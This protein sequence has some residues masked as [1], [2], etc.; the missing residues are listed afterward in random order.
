MKKVFSLITLL[1]IFIFQSPSPPRAYIFS[2]QIEENY[3]SDTT[4]FAYFKSSWEYSFIEQYQKALWAFDQV[5]NNYPNLSDTE[6]AYFLSFR[7]INAHKY[8]IDRA[9]KEKL[10][11]I[12]EAHHQPMHRTFTTSLLEDLYKKGYRFLGLEALAHTDSALNERGYPI[13]SSGFYTQEPQFGN[14]IRK[15]LELGFYVFPYDVYSGDGKER[16]IQQAK[17]IQKVIEAFPEGKFIIHCGFDHLIEDEIPNWE[18]AMAGRVREYTGINPF[19]INQVILTEHYQRERENPY[20]R[21]VDTL[22]Q[23]SVFVKDNGTL[24]NGPKGSS[25]YDIRLYHPRTTYING[26]PHWMTMNGKRRIYMIDREKIN[27]EYPVIVKAYLSKEKDNAVP[28]DVI[29]I[30]EFSDQKAL[31]LPNGNYDL[32][33]YNNKGESFSIKIKVD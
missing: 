3:K 8:I 5:V 7:P 22:T 1:P 29:E 18:K 6:K 20:F 11:I 12:N 30:K 25:H 26:R 16:E 27:I 21:M 15:A 24:F 33:L 4:S 9:E 2:S 19:T 23:A 32:K 10:I 17:N 28:V 14:L 31:V 13:L